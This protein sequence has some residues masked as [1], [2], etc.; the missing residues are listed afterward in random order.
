MPNI[1]Q[2]RLI[3]YL[4]IAG[5]LPVLLAAANLMTKYNAIDQLQNEIYQVQNLALS[6][7][8]KQSLNM[9]VRE[10]FR[11][12]DHFYIDK[13]LETLS[14]LDTEAETLQKLV[15]NK[16]FAGDENVKKRLE[17]ISGP[18]NDLLFSEGNVQ[19]YPFF[20]ETISSMV[21][22]IEVNLEDLKTILALV[23]GYQIGPYKSGPNR[24]QLIVIDF[25]L[26]RK[27]ATE[28]N[29]VF[30]INMKLLKREYAS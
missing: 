29:E 27:E 13:H 23:E 17:F 30:L 22:P 28:K 25:K 14:F 10:H 16:Y 8:K 15:N 18:T 4:I 12:A 6:R 3:L 1:P 5:L 21:H 24:P 11:G 7:E 26:D 19:S 9:I 2:S 20:Q